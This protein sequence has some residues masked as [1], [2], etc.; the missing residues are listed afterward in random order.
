MHVVCLDFFFLLWP[1]LWHIEVPRARD[2][3]QAAKHATA[4]ARQDP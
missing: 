3:I 2:E 1:H 4:V